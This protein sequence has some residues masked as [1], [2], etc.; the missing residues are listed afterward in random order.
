MLFSIWE[1]FLNTQSLISNEIFRCLDP[2]LL[3]R[4][5]IELDICVLNRN[6]IDCIYFSYSWHFHLMNSNRGCFLVLKNWNYYNFVCMAVKISIFILEIRIGR[7][8]INKL[9]AFFTNM[10][11]MFW[12][13]RF[14][15][16]HK[17][18]YPYSDR[19][20]NRPI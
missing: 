16:N 10:W 4:E 18:P 20:R 2:I 11:L 19:S 14:C 17:P 12:H 8:I 6:F 7:I 3:I 15:T 9:I 13:Y 5:G 1:I